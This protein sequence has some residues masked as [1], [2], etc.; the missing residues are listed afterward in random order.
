LIKEGHSFYFL[1]LLDSGVGRN[2]ASVEI[3]IKGCSLIGR[4]SRRVGVDA[5]AGFVVVCDVSF[6]FFSELL[7]FACTKN[8]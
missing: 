2:Q 5:H 1:H 8:K 6:R 3:A 4:G 7:F